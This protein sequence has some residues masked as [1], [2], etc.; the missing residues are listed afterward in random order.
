MGPLLC[1]YPIQFLLQELEH[2]WCLSQVLD[3]QYTIFIEVPG[4]IFLVGHF[5]AD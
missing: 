5:I 2:Y 3:K 1:L 4:S